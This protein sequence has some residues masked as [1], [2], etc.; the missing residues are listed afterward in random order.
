V[1]CGG[2]EPDG[3]GPPEILQV[4]VRERGAEGLEARLAYGDHEDIGE[5]DD[6][7]VTDAVAGEGQRIR[8]VFDQLL[9]GNFLEEV[10]C[11]DG[12]WAEVPVGMDFDDVARCAGAD[13]SRCGGLCLDH[14]GILDDNGDGAFDDTRLIEGAVVLTCGGAAVPLD[15]QR[16][17][18]QPSGTQRISAGS[19][20]T[21]ALGPAVV[22]VAAGGLP[23][24]TTCGLGF[25]DRVV[26]RQ[27]QPVGDTGD[28]G[29]G[30]EPFRVAASEPPDGAVDVEAG[31]TIAI[32]LNATLDAGSVAG[33]VALSAG[34]APVAVTAEVDGASI[35]V[36]V[37]GG[38]A[39][40]TEH[41]VTLSVGIADVFGDV[42]AADTTI[43]WSTR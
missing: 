24:G 5:E 8:V 20:G 30:V 16:S 14:G 18:Y 40:A 19:A 3:A 22:L 41:V 27:D 39:A 34:G 1:G 42:L 2:A 32:H 36:T 28:I 25:S 37:P 4:L 7:E 23:P 26:D 31:E 43:T 29:F 9:R 38:L 12:S 15:L 17:Y 21:D 11:A 6:R 13:L 10:A 33:R 35:V